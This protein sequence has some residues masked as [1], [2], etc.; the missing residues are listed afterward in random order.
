MILNSGTLTRDSTES[1]IV[2]FCGASNATFVMNGGK[3]TGNAFEG[4]LRLVNN[5]TFT[6]TGGEITGVQTRDPYN[7]RGVINMAGSTIDAPMTNSAVATAI[8]TLTTP[9]TP[10][11]SDDS[12]YDD[13]RGGSSSGGGSNTSGGTTDNNN[14]S[15]GN[16]NSTGNGTVEG[17]ITETVTD[18]SGNVTETTVTES[19][20]TVETATDGTKTTT[21]TNTAVTTNA[22]T[23]EQTTV[24]TTETAVEAANG[25]TGTVTAD[26]NGNTVSAEATISTQAIAE[27]ATK[28]EA[29]TLPVEVKATSS[30]EDAAPVAVT[31]PEGSDKVTVEIPAENLTPGTVAVIVKADG[32]EEIVKTSTNGENGVVLTLDSSATIKLVDNTKS[33]GDV[34]GNEWFADNVAWS[35]SREIM[36]GIKNPDGSVIL[37]AQ[38]IATRAQVSAIAQ[39]FCE[40]VAR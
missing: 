33:F 32:T 4:A 3:I 13:D 6:M 40:K 25:S 19:V 7:F 12:G 2:D 34:T 28:N 8:Y 27:A 21:T 18:A 36:N 5:C 11:S 23:G 10:S 26:A 39:R 1:S 20:G 17:T 15:G 14:T 22:A 31:F 29:V 38:G 9:T 16:S 24:V 35:T 37:D 30:R